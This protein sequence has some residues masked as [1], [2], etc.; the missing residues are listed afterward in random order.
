V[1]TSPDEGSLTG[2]QNGPGA[3]DDWGADVGKG[4]S[5]SVVHDNGGANVRTADVECKDWSC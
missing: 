1:I 4:E 3:I 5:G 2:V